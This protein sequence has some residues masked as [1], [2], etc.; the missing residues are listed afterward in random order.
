MD[1]KE[2]S[3]KEKENEE[4]ADLNIK[5]TELEK[6]LNDEKSMKETAIKEKDDLLERNLKL[7]KEKNDEIYKKNKY[8]KEK[9]DILDFLEREVTCPVCLMIPKLRRYL[10]VGMGTPPVKHVK[11]KNQDFFKALLSQS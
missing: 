4:K 6:Q 7:E 2:T 5:I 11:G 8:K 9:D 1:R 3:M 10:S